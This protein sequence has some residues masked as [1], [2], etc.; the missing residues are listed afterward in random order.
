MILDLEHL[1][2]MRVTFQD[3]G[4]GFFFF[5]FTLVVKMSSREWISV[6]SS[7]HAERGLAISVVWGPLNGIGGGQSRC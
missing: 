6:R 3:F 7:F 5:A 1:P 4:F 2:K